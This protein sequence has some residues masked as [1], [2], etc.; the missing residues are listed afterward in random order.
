MNFLV[1]IQAHDVDD[2]LKWAGDDRIMRYLRWDT[3]TSRE[4]ALTYLGKVAIPYPWHWSI[5]LDGE[6]S[7]GYVSM[8]PGQITDTE[9]TLVML[10]AQ[11]TGGK[12]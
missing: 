1:S 9:H 11:I 6:R 4:E 12:G 2:F 3:I 7:I 8:R 5:S 10:W